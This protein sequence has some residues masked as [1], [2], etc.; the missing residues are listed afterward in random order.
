MRHNSLR[1]HDGVVRRHDHI[2]R[3][4]HPH[5]G[6]LHRVRRRHHELH[7]YVVVG[8]LVQN[9]H[10]AREPQPGPPPRIHVRLGHERGHGEEQV[11]RVR[12]HPRLVP[13]R[14]LQ[15]PQRGRELF[16]HLPLPPPTQTAPRRTARSST[17]KVGLPPRRERPFDS[18]HRASPP[19]CARR[20]YV[21]TTC[22]RWRGRG[23]ER[24]RARRSSAAAAA[25]AAAHG[26]DG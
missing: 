1:V 20:G 25:A 9:R 3:G 14:R 21:P 7:G 23:R 19:G 22:V 16:S 4:P 11:G 5:C 15:R 17:A 6:P 12:L 8:A 24:E 13:Q 18:S 10:R 2:G 26:D